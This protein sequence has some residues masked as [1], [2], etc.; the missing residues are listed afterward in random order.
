[1]QETS[2]IQKI[3][4]EVQLDLNEMSKQSVY[5]KYA[6]LTM[7]EI[8]DTMLA[9]CDEEPHVRDANFAQLDFQ[10]IVTLQ[11]DA[12]QQDAREQTCKQSFTSMVIMRAPAGSTIRK[13]GAIRPQTGGDIT[14]S[15]GLSE[16]TQ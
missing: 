6:Y 2:E 1:M 14:Y 15:E 4:E 13:L 16:S 5:K 12:C 10:D 7:K 8:R 11:E 9:P 3:S